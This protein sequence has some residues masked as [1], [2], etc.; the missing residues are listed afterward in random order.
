MTPN[1][2]DETLEARAPDCGLRAD[3]GLS[4]DEALDRIAVSRIILGPGKTC[5]R[6]AGAQAGSGA[7]LSFQHA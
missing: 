7:T 1:P 3:Y 6:P 4:P 2:S 5:T